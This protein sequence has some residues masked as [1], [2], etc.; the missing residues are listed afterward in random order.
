[1]KA[2]KDVLRELRTS[3]N[4]TQDE[5]A[6]KL[7]IGRSRISMY[8]RGERKPDFETLELISDFFNV[9]MNFLLGK[10]NLT[11]TVGYYVND[12]TRKIAQ[13][14]YQN[15]ELS[16]LFDAARDASPDDL[17]TVHT[18]LLALKKKEEH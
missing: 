11:T 10:T 16:L 15:K 5:L 6:Q 4:L 8:E 12:D 1:M 14:I 9:D 2:F 17:K 18:M 3:N 7:N 13:E